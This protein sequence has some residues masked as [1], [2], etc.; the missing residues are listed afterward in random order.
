LLKKL[1]FRLNEKQN[2]QFEEANIKL[3]EISARVEKVLH[4]KS[5]SIASIEAHL[6]ELQNLKVISD[7]ECKLE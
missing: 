6:G 1:P 3:A 2:K 7:L 5:V 4:D